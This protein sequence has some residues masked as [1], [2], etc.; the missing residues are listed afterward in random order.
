[1]KKYIIAAALC[2]SAAASS[3]AAPVTAFEV[4]NVNAYT[5]GSWAFGERFTVGAEDI[6]VLSLGAYD[7]G[8]DGFVTAGGI[9]VGLYLEGSNTLLAS[10]SVQSGDTLNGFYRYASVAPVTLSANTSYRLVAVSGSDAYTYT[11]PVTSAPGL[12]W[13]GYTYCSSTSLTGSCSAWTG[14][15]TTWMGNF[16]YEIAGQIGEVPEPASLG[17]LAVGGLGL[18]MARRRKRAA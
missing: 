14:T 15:D 7:A 2:A 17:L 10:T 4:S 12:T 18:A 5:N 16:Q 11:S 9:Q 6:S 1:M 3:H 8:G 13:Q